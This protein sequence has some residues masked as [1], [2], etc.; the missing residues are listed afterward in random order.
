[1]KRIREYTDFGLWVKMTLAKKCITQKELSEETGL[2]Q[3]TI[4]EILTGKNKKKE[5]MDMI[6]LVLGEKREE[7]FNES[8]KNFV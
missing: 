5:N 6:Q 4:T 2:A 8:S 3:S 7:V 1:M